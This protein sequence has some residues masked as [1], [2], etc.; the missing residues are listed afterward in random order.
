MMEHKG[1]KR[2]E[3]ERLIL[4]KYKI[5]DAEE[6]FVNWASSPVVT[7][8]LTWQPYTRTSDVRLYIKSR[9]EAYQQQDCYEWVIE[10]KQNH[11]V[12]G[13]I[14]VV[15]IDE[16]K[17]CAEVGYCLSEA[18]WGQGIMTEAFRT[19]IRFLFCDIG[20]ERIEAK[21]DSRNSAS[22]KVMEKCGLKIENLVPRDSE[23]TENAVKTV[24]RALFRKDYRP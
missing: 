5:T 8:Y 19:V 20:F 17:N 22:G 16:Q 6:M 18:Y 14:S 3:T 11:Q 13:S 23:S 15:N 2:L 24:V 4:R 1:T 9:I 10:W 12:I 7:R 21:H